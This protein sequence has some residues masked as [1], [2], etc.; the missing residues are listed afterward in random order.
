MSKRAIKSEQDAYDI[1]TAIDISKQVFSKLCLE[2]NAQNDSLAKIRGDLN[3]KTNLLYE[4]SKELRELRIS[5][6]AQKN[7]QEK[8]TRQVQR[9]KLKHAAPPPPPHR[10]IV[11][12]VSISGFNEGGWISRVKVFCRKIGL[13]KQIKT[14][15]KPAAKKLNHMPGQMP[16]TRAKVKGVKAK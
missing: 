8:T 15:S 4:I 12:G 6:D 5:V 14:K 9:L 11:E 16:E 2:L 13:Q 1:Q 3:T 10:V 7:E